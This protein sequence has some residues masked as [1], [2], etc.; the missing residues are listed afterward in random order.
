LYPAHTHAPDCGGNERASSSGI[1]IFCQ[2]L[3]RQL[4]GIS[5]RIPSAWIFFTGHDCSATFKAIMKSIK[6]SVVCPVCS[7]PAGFQ[8]SLAQYAI[9]Y[10]FF[11]STGFTHPV[12]RN[13][14]SYYTHDYWYGSGILMKT[15]AFVFRLAQKRRLCWI[16]KYYKRGDVL[17]VGAGMGI[18]GRELT[19]HGF[20][21]TSIDAAFAKLDNPAV[22][23]IDFL[24]WITSK[25]Y[26]V[27]VFWESLEHVNDPDAYLMKA[28]SLLKPNGKVFI[29]YPRYGCIESVVFGKYWYDLDIP[30]HLFHFTFKGMDRLLLRTGF[31]II[32]HAGIMAFDYAPWGCA[33]SIVSLLLRKPPFQARRD[34]TMLRL[35]VLLPFLVAGELLEVVLFLCG[36]SPIQLVVAKK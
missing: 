5:I 1:V 11:C 25:R 30:R 2:I 10:C 36:Q 26:D 8:L 28:K 14:A 4:L 31:K 35:F 23:N 32:H 21:V 20:N 19:K 16:L 13:I 33:Q 29:E 3:H 18:F 34:M 6:R 22:Q 7:H 17:D 12:P 27:V 24:S 15:K 9:W